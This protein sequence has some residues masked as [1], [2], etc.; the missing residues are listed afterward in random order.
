MLINSDS[1]FYRLFNDCEVDHVKH[2]WNWQGNKTSEGYGRVNWNGSLYLAHR[3][4]LYLH[5]VIS[6]NVLNNGSLVIMHRCDNPACLNP[7]HLTIATQRENIADRTQKKRSA[8]HLENRDKQGR[9]M[10]K[11]INRPL[12]H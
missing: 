2:C 1:E 12:G 5:D 6:F 9:F 11:R 7:D 10:K 4:S 3:L 8:R